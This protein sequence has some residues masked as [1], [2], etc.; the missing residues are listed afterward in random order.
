MIENGMGMRQ[1]SDS[2]VPT[3]MRILRYIPKKFASPIMKYVSANPA[4]AP[5]ISEIR[6]RLGALFSITAAGKNISIFNSE[7][8]YCDS[9]DMSQTLGLLCE[10]S[11]HTYGDT[12]R[13]GYILLDGG[14]RIG[15]CGH[16]RCEGNV[17]KSVYGITAI[18]I[19]IPHGV[20]GICDD[21][22]PLL[23]TDGRIN[24]ALIYSP[25]GVGKTTL[26]RDIAVKLRGRRISLIDTRG[27]LFMEESMDNTLIDVLYGYPRAKGIEIATRTMSAEVIICDE[28]GSAEEASAILA[29]QNSGVPLIASAHADSLRSLFMRPNIKLLFEHGIFRYY[30]GL[31]RKAGGSAFE[32][33]IYDAAGEK[34]C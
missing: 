1:I 26:L 13:E 20:Y 7:R 23:F 29:A 21:I 19:R 17:L 15:I 18:S 14:Y 25:P 24:S 8:I 22:L 6:L 27:E 9:D 33:E 32:F 12:M 28:I 30:I 16:A 5:F 31:S 11:I 34:T 3:L 4:A 10:D 2:E